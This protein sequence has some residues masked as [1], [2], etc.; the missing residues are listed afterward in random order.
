MSNVK[1]KIL[2]GDKVIWT[3]YFFFII[4]S[5][6]EVFSAMGKEVAGGSFLP[7]ILRHIVWLFIGVI[8]C[9]IFHRIDY[10]K[11]TSI[12]K[13][14]LFVSIILVC[15]P[16]LQ[17]TFNHL[18]LSTARWIRLNLFF[19]NL[20]FQ[21]SEMVKYT[22]IFYMCMIMANNQEKIKDKTIFYSLIIPLS[23]VCGIVFWSNFSTC[24]LIFITCFI[25]MRIGGV[26][27]KYL[28]VMLCCLI[29]LL[30]LLLLIASFSDE[31]ASKIGRL[32]TVLS[33][34]Q[35]HSNTD[36][37]IL[38]QS[39]QSLTAIATGGLFGRGIGNSIQSRFLDEAH[40]DF[41]FSII[42]EEGGILLGLVVIFL[43]IILLYR[44]MRITRNTHGYFAAMA[45]LGFGI[46]ITMQAIVNMCVAVDL[47]PVTGQ[48]LPFISYGG[49]SF[50]IASIFLGI[51]INMSKTIENKESILI[52]TNVTQA[53]TEKNND[54]LETEP[55]G[56]VQ[57]KEE[58][59]L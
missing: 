28:Y 15:V 3:V 54:K 25:L 32:A 38:N 7:L 27:K 14:L 40:N 36:Y 21:P 24:G 31:F 35:S 52:N 57:Q 22:I 30:G 6:T 34:T 10:R 9:F 56:S 1:T 26:N 2:K 19:Y 29:A 18:P 33:R 37:T 16:Y 45:C 51:V 47:I 5:I 44:L 20:Q 13:V 49:T 12:L 50:V 4:I 59:N 8:C 17:A 48:T 46:A 11:I 42:L 58:E 55:D 39:N 41:I 53:K 23:I 43:Y